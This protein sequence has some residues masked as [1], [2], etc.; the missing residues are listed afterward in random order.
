V[1]A[2]AGE[3]EVS[4]AAVSMHVGQLRKEFDDLLFTRTSSGLAFT[5]GGLR[6]A[7]RAVEILGLQDRTVRE[8]SQAGDGRR[9]LRVAAS[10]LFAEHAAP[11]LIELFASRAKDLEVELS[12]HSAAD[13]PA[14][15]ATRT[16]DVAIG[17]AGKPVDSLSQLPFLLY[18][19]QAVA[20]PEHP[21][22][23]RTLT[24]DQIRRQSWNL[25]PSAIEADGVV[26]GMLRNLGVPEP[27]QRI[28]QSHAA[29]L[30]ETTRGNGAALA[31]G[32]SVSGDLSAGRLVS[33]EGPGL[34]AQGRWTATALPREHQTP[35]AAELLR[36]I[37]TPRASQAMVRGAGVHLGRFKPA[38]HVTLWS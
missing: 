12:V 20:G 4:E 19:V 33:L 9:V 26:P 38:V 29:A 15:L 27:Q 24:S 36:F 5:P 30:E 35:A 13:F 37:T 16:V 17:P 28:F 21:L 18:E 31:V 23:G 22:A 14:L 11:G 25:G 34:R 1:K 7:S 32:F 3:L 8:V 6:L 2:A 10:N